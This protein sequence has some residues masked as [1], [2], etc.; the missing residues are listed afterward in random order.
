MGGDHKCPVCQATF[1]RP[2]HVARHM[3]SHTGDR[4][5]KCQ[6]CGDQFARRCVLFSIFH[7]IDPWLGRASGAQHANPT[8]SD[9]LSRHVNKCHAAEKALLSSGSGSS[10]AALNS[11]GGGGRRKG[12][13]AATRATTS[14]QA[15]DQC[16]QSSLPCDGSNPCA[17]CVTRK[18]R[19]TFVKFHRQ[20]APVGPGHP[21]SLSASTL[22]SGH[23]P[24]LSASSSGHPSLSSS[25][26]SG[27]LMLGGIGGAG[28][29]GGGGGPFLYAQQQAGG[30]GYGGDRFAH[31][32]D[33]GPRFAGGGGGGGGGSNAGSPTSAYA[34]G[35]ERREREGLPYS[36]APSGPF[37]YPPGAGAGEFE[38]ADSEHSGHSASGGSR[39]ASSA[40]GLVSVLL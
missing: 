39:P 25:S 28:G 20:T 14:K 21:S 8:P 19:C 18:T 38:Y 30:G 12:T 32:P 3:R 11:L 15:C 26:L 27:D 33:S 24:S 37:S 2:Q 36:Y 40:G 22:P 34:D 6:H 10:A 4:P 9:L 31:H 7:F 29:G 17:K 1:T 5:Y 13:T 23:L 35:F 16:V